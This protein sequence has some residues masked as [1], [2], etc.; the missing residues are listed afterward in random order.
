M[1]DDG[2]D[3]RFSECRQEAE[4][5]AHQVE[6]PERRQ[7]VVVIG[8]PARGASV[9]A[10]IR[11]DHVISGCRQRH[12]NV[13]PAIG[14]FGK[15]VQQKQRRLTGRIVAASSRCTVRPLLFSTKRARMPSGRTSGPRGESAGMVVVLGWAGVLKRS[16]RL[17]CDRFRRKHFR[18]R[19]ER[20]SLPQ[21]KN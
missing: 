7:V 3:G 8:G 13:P 16:Q 11:R 18:F 9:A 6:N 21:A 12:H 15:A 5:V 20:E 1:A 14:E 10:M 19:L 17:G 2:I 4:L